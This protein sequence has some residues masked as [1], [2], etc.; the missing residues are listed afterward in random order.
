VYGLIYN[1]R[2][3]QKNMNQELQLEIIKVIE[4]LQ[5]QFESKYTRRELELLRR[6][7]IYKDVPSGE[8]VSDV[9]Y[10][11]ELNELVKNQISI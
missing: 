11:K 5:S 10:L 4:T 9:K 3:K 6:K 1:I 8:I 7:Y 2:K